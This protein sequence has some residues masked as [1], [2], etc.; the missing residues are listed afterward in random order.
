MLV[1]YHSSHTSSK[2]LGVTVLTHTRAAILEYSTAAWG[3]DNDAAIV[4]T[5]SIVHI[6]PAAI[7]LGVTGTPTGEG[8]ATLGMAY[9]ACC[10]CEGG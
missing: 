5:P 1:P 6:V 4:H 10:N 8:G 2:T 3:L 9:I 7:T